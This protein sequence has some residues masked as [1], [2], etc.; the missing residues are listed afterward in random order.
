[1]SPKHNANVQYITDEEGR[2]KSVVISLEDYEEILEDISDLAAIAER[3][4]D[5]TIS[6]D[7]LLENLKKDGLL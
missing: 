3:R 1:M 7:Q 4:N 2:K 5:P 6:L